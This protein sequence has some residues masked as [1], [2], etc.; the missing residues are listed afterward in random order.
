[1]CP[2]AVLVLSRTEGGSGR[3][4]PATTH[5][6]FPLQ[7][8]VNEARIPDQKYVTLKL[9]DVIRFGYDILPGAA[10]P[11][12]LSLGPPGHSCLVILG[13]G[14]GLGSHSW[15]DRGNP[16]SSSG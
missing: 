16:G 15:G 11:P 12:G 6:P 7:T 10:C 4:P 13:A 3:S 5:R 14:G 2:R 1:M 9:N 8:F